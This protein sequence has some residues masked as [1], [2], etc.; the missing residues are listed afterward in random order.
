M[1][2]ELVIMQEIKM[3]LQ[4]LCLCVKQLHIIELKE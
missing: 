4:Q 3:E 1:D 2:G